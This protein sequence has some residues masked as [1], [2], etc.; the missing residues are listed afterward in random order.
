MEHVRE[1]TSRT[2]LLGE[3][4]PGQL[5]AD[6]SCGDTYTAP[7]GGNEYAALEAAH[8]LHVSVAQEAEGHHWGEDPMTGLTMRHDGPQDDCK[9]IGC[10]REE[11]VPRGE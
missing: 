2:T 10:W 7:E 5:L 4:E 9:W 11:E 8:A 3:G 1:T 6:C